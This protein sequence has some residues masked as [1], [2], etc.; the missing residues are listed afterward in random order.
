VNLKSAEEATQPEASEA[1]P[2]NDDAQSEP[3]NDQQAD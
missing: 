1:Q 2:A 3:T